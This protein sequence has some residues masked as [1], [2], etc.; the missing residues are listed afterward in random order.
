MFST[1]RSIFNSQD[2]LPD[3]L[4]LWNTLSMVNR[5]LVRASRGCVPPWSLPWILTLDPSLEWYGSGFGDSHAYNFEVNSNIR[6]IFSTASLG[7]IF[8][9]ATQFQPSTFQHPPPRKLESRPSCYC[10]KLSAG[11]T[12][13]RKTSARYNN[14]GVGF[15]FLPW[16]LARS[17]RESH[18]QSF[19]RTDYYIR[20]MEKANE[21]EGE[22]VHVGASRQG[23]Q[24]WGG[25][26]CRNESAPRFTFAQG[27]GVYGVNRARIARDEEEG[28]MRMRVGAGAGM[29]RGTRERGR[30]WERGGWRGMRFRPAR[31]RQ[32]GRTAQTAVARSPGDGVEGLRVLSVDDEQDAAVRAA[33]RKARARGREQGKDVYSG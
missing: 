5:T 16:K 17:R 28:D 20:G 1:N 30:E 26:R 9:R 7:L 6:N 10:V 15:P 3:P 27:L 33:R 11:A 8:R 4:D 31:G 2:N 23:A 19:G 25:W 22:H 21:G 12:R 24:S 14:D 13:L 18:T 29:G 32:G